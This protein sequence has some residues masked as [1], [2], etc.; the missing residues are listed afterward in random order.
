MVRTPKIRSQPLPAKELEI[1]LG[2]LLKLRSSRKVSIL[3]A[4]ELHDTDED[5]KGWI[6]LQKQAFVAR[7]SQVSGH[8]LMMGL[9]MSALKGS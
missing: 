7:I 6:R 4:K 3:H 1:L 2:G 9:S 5:F 8:H